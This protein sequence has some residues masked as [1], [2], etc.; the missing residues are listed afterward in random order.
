MTLGNATA[1]SRFSRSNARVATALCTEEEIK[2]LPYVQMLLDYPCLY[3]DI[4]HYNVAFCLCSW[5]VAA[6]KRWGKVVDAT[7]H[8]GG[9]C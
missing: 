8:E 3:V 7:S 4:Q 6:G 5:W 1:D 9:S 2:M